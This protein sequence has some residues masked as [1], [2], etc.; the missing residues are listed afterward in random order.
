MSRILTHFPCLFPMVPKGI[1]FTGL[2][3]ALGLL[4]VLKGE[5]L[6]ILETETE[7][8][9]GSVVEASASK[10]PSRSPAD[11][12]LEQLRGIDAELKQSKARLEKIYKAEMAETEAADSPSLPLHK[13]MEAAMHSE[14]SETRT[15]AMAYNQATRRQKHLINKLVELSQSVN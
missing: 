4:P 8:V 7:Q 12:I 10:K 11:L 5:D 2:F 6:Q 14:Q 3:L 9:S 15:L 13:W 1:R